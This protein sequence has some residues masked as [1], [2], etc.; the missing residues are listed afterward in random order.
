MSQVS[1]T[2]YNAL[3]T[4]LA[5]CFYGMNSERYISFMMLSTLWRKF[6][7]SGLFLLRSS[8]MVSKIPSTFQ[9]RNKMEIFSWRSRKRYSF[10]SQLEKNSKAKTGI[11][12]P[13]LLHSFFGFYSANTKN[14][15]VNTLKWNVIIEVH[16]IFG[17]SILFKKIHYFDF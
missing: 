9:V 7:I 5:N 2:W 8:L 15:S 13:N 17:S 3:I 6:D 4:I 14:I 16:V 11:T 10:R 12:L 1:K